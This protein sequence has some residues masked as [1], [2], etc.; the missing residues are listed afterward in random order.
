MVIGYSPVEMDRREAAGMP[1]ATGK[2][3]DPPQ[4]PAQDDMEAVA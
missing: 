2:D 3:P 1:Y 4:A